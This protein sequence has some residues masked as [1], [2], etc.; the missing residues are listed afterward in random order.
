MMSHPAA[1]VVF[2]GATVDHSAAT[3]ATP[4][5]HA[6]NPGR[7]ATAVG[8]VGFNVA[9]VLARLGHPVRMVT[10]I[11]SDGDGAAVLAAGHEAGVDMTSAAV[12]DTA[13][14]ATYRAAFDDRGDLIIGI[15]DMAVLDEITAD[16]AATAARAGAPRETVVL[17]AN[18]PAATLAH[19]TALATEAGQGTAAIGVSPAKVV[20]L[21][22]LLDRIG[23]LFVTRREAAALLGHADDPA[24]STRSLAVRLAERGVAHVV[25]TDSGEPLAAAAGGEVHLFPPFPAHVRSVNGAGDALAAGILHGIANRRSFFD[26][27]LAGLAAAAITVEDP[28]TV[29]A[30]LSSAAVEARIGKARAVM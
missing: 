6:S 9:R 8:G 27:I 22:P 11:G 21:A 25:V 12:S 30:A 1:F 29:A 20:R 4:V 16:A 18:L 24:V 28:A 10:R 26:A 7:A 3:I 15:A 13:R 14:T 2:G 5:M 19:L 17:D 23:H